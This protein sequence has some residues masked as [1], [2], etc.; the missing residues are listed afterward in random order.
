[1]ETL[2]LGFVQTTFRTC[3]AV[4]SLVGLARATHRATTL[5]NAMATLYVATEFA[6]QF[7]TQGETYYM[8]EPTKTKRRRQDKCYL[9][10]NWEGVL[11]AKDFSKKI[12]KFERRC[13]DYLNV[14]KSIKP[15]ADIKRRGQTRLLTNLQRNSSQD[16]F[17]REIDAMIDA[18]N[19]AVWDGLLNEGRPLSSKKRRVRAR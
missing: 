15:T 1:M 19:E 6:T 4:R 13:R 3:T 14:V 10:G 18:L 7:Q 11:I 9:D 8:P 12:K 2:P 5:E 16:K 17:E